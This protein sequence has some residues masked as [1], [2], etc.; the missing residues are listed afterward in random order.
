MIY[1]YA[2]NS[3]QSEIDIIKSYKDLDRDEFCLKCTSKMCHVFKPSIKQLLKM[4]G[5]QEASEFNPGLGQVV[6]GKSHVKEICKEKGL[7]EI[8]NETT[9]TIHKHFDDKRAEAADKRW[10]EADKGAW[11]GNGE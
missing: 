6:R 7:E 10:E 2:C 9:E 1:S 11:V 3:C 4:G 5:M 8:G